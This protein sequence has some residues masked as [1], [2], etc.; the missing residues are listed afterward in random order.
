MTQ[1]DET[2]L[3]VNVLFDKENG[4]VVLNLVQDERLIS[5]GFDIHE[6]QVLGMKLAEAVADAMAHKLNLA[7]PKIQKTLH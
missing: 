1:T 4:L 5:A 3:K 7:I 6:A 2:A